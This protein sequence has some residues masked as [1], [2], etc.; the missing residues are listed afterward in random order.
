MSSIVVLTD[1]YVA[2]LRLH[3]VPSFQLWITLIGHLKRN[4]KFI[5]LILSVQNVSCY[6][7]EIQRDVTQIYVF[8]P[9]T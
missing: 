3:L 4:M 5:K 7:Y 8:A 6:A 9:T 1:P 2:Q